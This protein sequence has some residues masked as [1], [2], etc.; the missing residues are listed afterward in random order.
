[1][2]VFLSLRCSLFFA[3]M[4]WWR[5]R[6][7]ALCCAQGTGYVVESFEAALW[8]FHHSTSFEDGC[9]RA[10][11]QRSPNLSLSMPT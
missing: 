6:L 1:M 2:R 8:A 9:L 3:L 4:I 11:T 10:G 7:V 5:L